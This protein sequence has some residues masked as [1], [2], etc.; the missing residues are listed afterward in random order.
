MKHSV[1]FKIDSSKQQVQII[2]DANRLLINRN[3]VGMLTIDLL[4]IDLQN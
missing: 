2:V 1:N 4:S 3:R